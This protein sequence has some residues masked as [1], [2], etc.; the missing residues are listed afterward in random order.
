MAET[1]K[2][3]KLVVPITT[4]EVL[5][6]CPAATTAIVQACQASNNHSAAAALTVSWT[7]DSDSDAETKLTNA[8]S[9]PVN[10]PVCPIEPGMVLEA[11][12]TVKA[13][14]SVDDVITL[15]LS[16]IEITA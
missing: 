12:D 8:L 3:A 13:V 15:T 4:A 5:Y 6:T 10:T 2:N 7:D 9:I 11:G 16:V 1:F 14:A